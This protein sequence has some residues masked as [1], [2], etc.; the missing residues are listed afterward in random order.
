MTTQTAQQIVGRGAE[1]DVLTGALGT[2][3]E[4]RGRFL[5][6]CGEPGIGKT[7]LAQA[8]AD[9]A[10]QANVPAYWGFAW[11]AGGAPA[12]WPWMQLLRSLIEAQQ[13]CRERLEGLAQLLPELAVERGD[14]IVLQPDQARFQL[15]EAV[16]NLLEA[17]SREHCIVLLLEDL[18]AADTD[19][20]M[21]LHYLGSHVRSL[22][23][24]L[25]GT[26]RDT[27]ARASPGAE[28][29]WRAARSAEV[30]R[31]AK[32]GAADVNLYLQNR[33]GS[34]PDPHAIEKLLA[35]T[36]G[37]PLFLTELIGLA[38]ESGAPGYQFP[39]SLQRVFSQQ[40][41]RLPAPAVDLLGAA[42]VLGRSVHVEE[43]AALLGEPVEQVRLLAE[44]ALDTGILEPEDEH[45]LRFH[46][47]L[48]RD[49]LFHGLD[50]K[51]RESLSLKHAEKVRLQIAAG[52]TDRAAE[53]ATHLSR[54]GADQRRAAVAAWRSAAARASERIAFEDAVEALRSALRVLG[55]GPQVTAGER[56]DA[57]LELAGATLITGDLQKG[58]QICREAFEIARDIGNPDL[59]ARAALTYGSAIVVAKVDRE[60]VSMLEETLETLPSGDMANRARV[61]ARLAGALQPSPEP[62]TPLQMARD[63]I[64][65]ARATGDERVLHEVL[66]SAVSA[67]MDFAL[68]AERIPLNQEFGEL[69][70]RLGDLPGLFRS[71]L[72]LV[73]DA[74]ESG[75]GQMLGEALDACAG[76]AR[77]IALPHYQWRVESLQALKATIQGR[78]VAALRHLS[79]AEALAGRVEDTGALLTIPL[80]RLLIFSDW[81]SP[82]TASL[83]SVRATLDAAF[84]VFPDAEIYCRA[85]MQSFGEGESVASMLDDGPLIDRFLSSGD[86]LSIAVL[87]ELAA[88]LG[89]TDIVERAYPEL[90]PFE[91]QC[92]TLGLMGTGWYGP[93]ARSLGLMAAALGQQDAAWRHFDTAQAISQRMQAGPVAAR[94]QQDMAAL[95]EQVGDT[96]GAAA[97]R[98]GAEK[99]LRQFGMKPRRG[100]EQAGSAPRSAAERN[101]PTRT[102]GN[103]FSLTSQG[104]VWRI[105]YAGNSAIVRSSKGLDMLALL[106]ARPDQ[107]IH[108]LDLMNPNPD[109]SVDAGDAGPAIDERARAAYR[110]RIGELEEELEEAA[111]FGDA[112]RADAARA[113]IE[114]IT[115]ELSRAY[116]MGGRARSAGAAAERARVNVQRRL[117]DAI[118]R[119]DERLPGAGRYL[120]NSI[121]TGRYCRYR[122]A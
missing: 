80:Q 26:F 62:K 75:N 108:V 42:A 37:N 49:F 106:V 87:G 57:I 112:V 116:G 17:V 67:M 114:F 117:R 53:L 100:I 63:A 46:H 11:E 22:P 39:D 76:V 78:Y 54:A 56:C 13:P 73:I 74:G 55:T 10:A 104:D 28:V 33:S 40:I 32:L 109:G 21:L 29:L 69:A 2:S 48:C 93:I 113:E 91:D 61:S 77:R 59:M 31:P 96:A 25:L 23:I 90:L 65:M 45:R 97:Y 92:A 122:P 89:R 41:E 50:R 119:I 105:D 81:D 60:L 102:P 82:A 19:S 103:L 3:R 83:E 38:N 14:G 79:E 107:E 111:A 86:R 24:M 98:A 34:T 99:L 85:L 43:L 8:T 12:Y 51:V 94:I 9:L 27:E 115:R 66:H 1:L 72:R 52:A 16:R 88:R 18:H 121:K 20:L 118:R 84:A 68:A 44:P 95:A 30:L 4:G 47:G 15:M 110:T 7:T 70:A 36:D 6:I 101:Q 5:L 58:H 120:E 64:R 71:K 35:I